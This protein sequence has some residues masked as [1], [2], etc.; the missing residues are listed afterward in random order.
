MKPVHTLETQYHCMQITKNTIAFLN[1]NQT[2]TDVYDQPF[3]ALTKEIRIRKPEIFGSDKY[4]SL[5]A[6]LPVEHCLLSLH[7]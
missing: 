1:P 2:P 5:L 4:F 7:G 3:Y 6:G